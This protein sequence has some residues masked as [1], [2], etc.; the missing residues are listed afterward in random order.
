MQLRE[1]A[2]AMHAEL[3]CRDPEFVFQE[4]STDTRTLEAGQLFFALSGERFD[5]HEFLDQVKEKGACAAVVSNQEKANAIEGLDYLLVPDVTRALG[6]LAYAW[7]KQ[8]D[9]NV[10]AVT[11][12]SGKTTVKEMMASILAQKGET[13][14][15]QGNFNNEIG[16]PLTL[17]RLRPEHRYAVIELGANHQGEIAYTVQLVEP[18]VALINN[19]A[20]AHVEGFGS[21]DGVAQAKSEIYGGLGPKGVAVI[22]QDDRYCDF[23]EQ[24]TSVVPQLFYS[25]QQKADVWLKQAELQEDGCYRITVQTPSETINVKLP[26]MGRHNIANALAAITGLLPLE[27]TKSEIMTGLQSLQPVPGRMNPKPLHPQLLVI[28][29]S[30]N[31]NEGSVRAAI[32]VLA[33][34]QGS[35]I[36]C[37]GELGELGEETAEVL[38]GIGRYAREAGIDELI[39]VGEVAADAADAFEGPWVKCDNH[40]QAVDAI[41]ALNSEQRKVILVKGSRSAKMENVVSLLEQQH[42]QASPETQPG[43]K[44]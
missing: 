9:L 22:N 18:Q 12:S 14:A 10:V 15:T 31:A 11:G 23:W 3:H 41:L 40:Q 2:Q 17:F 21:L 37:L 16:V 43:E 27:V 30:Y 26:L 32:D 19:A 13:L 4:V 24:K 7:R 36:L 6:H 44:P 29:D 34:Q 35:K 8:F 1:A 39:T 25:V 33:D 28:D 5:A 42:L 38:A 20:K